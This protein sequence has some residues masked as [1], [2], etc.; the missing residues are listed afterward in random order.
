MRYIVVVLLYLVVIFPVLSQTKITGHVLD[1]SGQPAEGFVILSLPGEVTVLS[2]VEIDE[3]GGYTLF[4]GEKTDSICIRVSGM[5]IGKYVKVVPNKSQTVNF[6]VE[7]KSLELDEV[8]VKAEP[9][10]VR[11]D[12]TDYYVDSYVQQGDR[13][14]GDV[15]KKIP[16]IEVSQSGAI[17]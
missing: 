16:G 17:S 13:V 8:S 5:M 12:T 15:L 9:V 7:N 1:I 11:G 6:T 2:Y 3:K 10:V 14:I 4:Y